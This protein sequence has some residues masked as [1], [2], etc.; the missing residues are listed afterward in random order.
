M[1][2]RIFWVRAMKC[3]R[4]QTRPRFILSSERVFLGNGVWT[5]VNSK[6]KIPSMGKCPQRRIEP[7]MLWTA[8]P[9]TTNELFWPQVL[10][11]RLCL[12]S[13]WR[14]P[15]PQSSSFLCPCPCYFLVPHPAIFQPS[16]CSSFNMEQIIVVAVVYKL[17]VMGYR[18]TCMSCFSIDCFNP[19]PGAMSKRLCR[20]A[21][22]TSQNVRSWSVNFAASIQGNFCTISRESRE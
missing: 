8:S 5:H 21:G 11:S 10:H 16:S 4:A 3:M 22:R 1:N 15:E 19:L 18:P 2:V 13:A 6:G 14:S 20:A 17:A 7:A 9:N 12:S